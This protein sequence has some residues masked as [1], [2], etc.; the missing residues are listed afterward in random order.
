M[1]GGERLGVFG[2]TFDPVHNGH[3]AAAVNVRS[4]LGLDRVLMIPAGAPWQKQH[5]FVAPAA[6]RLAMLTAAIDGVDRLEVSTLEVDRD[7]PTYTAD[8]IE[9]LRA[10]HADAELFLILGAD[11][12]ADIDTWDRISVV[13][14]ETALVVVT[15]AGTPGGAAL[16]RRWSRV[17][18]VQIPALEISSSDLRR[19]AASGEPLDGLM[20]AAAI[21]CLRERGLYPGS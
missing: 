12:A 16:P 18:H 8:T 9:E 15:R 7:G 5:R 19:R 10:Q 20:P 17:H 11:A 2:G 4:A 6:D 3:V 21:R 13:E 14:R 1:A